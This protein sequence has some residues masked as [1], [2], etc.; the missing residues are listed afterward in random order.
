MRDTNWSSRRCIH[1]SIVAL[2]ATCCLPF[3]GMVLKRR[4][5]GCLEAQ[6]VLEM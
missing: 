6:A 3:C 2:S 5:A 4:A 1:A